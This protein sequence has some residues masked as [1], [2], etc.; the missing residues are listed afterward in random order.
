MRKNTE[1]TKRRM[2]QKLFFFHPS[3]HSWK[4][5]N[6]LVLPK[7]CWGWRYV[8]KPACN[9]LDDQIVPILISCT[10]TRNT[11]RNSPNSCYMWS[12]TWGSHCNMKYFSNKCK[13]KR[14]WLQS[15]LQT[16]E[17]ESCQF[18]SPLN[19]YTS[20]EKLQSSLLVFVHLGK[21]LMR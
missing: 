18:L 16:S 6:A 10:N 7:P 2:L 17:R 12:A 4:T 20:L 11:M 9:Y 15:S 1:I 8:T 5:E 3:L 13:W 21:K 14:G 19:Q